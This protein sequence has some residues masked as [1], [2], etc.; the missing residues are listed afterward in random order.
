MKGL[1]E[2]EDS[3]KLDWNQVLSLSFFVCLSFDFDFSGFELIDWKELTWLG[4]WWSWAF[5]LRRFDSD[6]WDGMAFLFFA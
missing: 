3:D 4:V 2:A 5:D 1:M 6:G